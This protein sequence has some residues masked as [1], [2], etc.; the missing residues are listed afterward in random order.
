MSMRQA[1]ERFWVLSTLLLFCA[2]GIFAG[3]AG[4]TSIVLKDGRILQGNMAMLSGLADNPLATSKA[5]ESSVRLIWMVD[6]NLRRTF[7]PKAQ[8]AKVQE[9]D[10][11]QVLVKIHIPQRVAIMGARIGHVGPIIA[12]TEFDS[13]GRRTFSM[14]SERGRLDVVQGITEITP[15]WTKV[16]GLLGKQPFVWSMS[17]ATSSI[18]R[19]TLQRIL[20]KRINPKKLESRLELVKLF[21]QSERYQDAQKELEEVI[22]DFPDQE[23]LKGEV[24]ALRQLHSRHIIDEISQRRKVGQHRLAYRLLQGFPTQD[25]A[26]ETL[27]QVR[28]ILAEYAESK[29]E[30]EKML[31][32]LQ[33][34]LDGIKEESLRKR[35][36]VVH[37]EIVSELNINTMDRLAAYLRLSDDEKTSDSEKFALAITGWLLGADEASSNLPVALSLYEVRNIVRRYLS[38]PV[39]VRRNA[40]LDELKRQEGSSPRQV[41]QLIARMKPP[42]ETPVSEKEGEAGYFTLQLPG[43]DKEP[44]VSYY[45]QL[46]P[47]YDPYRRYPAVVTLNGAG[48]TP[49][50][51]IDWWA[52]SLD[53]SGNRLGQASRHGY[54]VIA[55]DWA[56]EAQKDYEYSAREHAA[57]LSSLRDACRRFS[58]DTDRVYLSGHSM[59]GDAAW[60]IGLAHP[61]YWAG[62]IPIVAVADKYCTFYWEN[63]GNVPFYVLAGE[64]D[65]DKTVKNAR[66]LDRYFTKRDDVTVTEYLGRGHENFHDDIQRIYDWMGR[67]QRNFFPKKFT[68]ATMRTWDN[69]FW[70]LELSDF[71][72]RAAVDPVNWPPP[73]SGFRAVK[74]DATIGLNNSITIRGVDS[75]TVWLSPE[76]VDFSKPIRISINGKRMTGKSPIEPDLP[77]LLEDVR[78]RGERLHPFWAKVN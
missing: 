39:K 67:R 58:I 29:A 48:T 4:A 1:H 60:D 68:V 24:Q 50:Q 16:E 14:M 9:A 46:P 59:G 18:P 23:K 41:A 15:L 73:K 75:A 7:V 5:A 51:Q 74:V 55:V 66:D 56:K 11:N 54:I 12:I 78:S 61:D 6:D 20:A 52:G 70:W 45:V 62:V 26:G 33:K 27:Q 42:I 31:A 10:A 8:V 25:V 64:L 43:Y 69:Y 77:V 32:Q 71:P 36:Q 57:V 21:L 19:A 35:A 22:K 38:E 76:L 17:I 65:G 49:A 13:F 47:E 28:E 3:S 40:L 30:G 53:A 72:P 63:A 2:T 37:V 44:P 34:N